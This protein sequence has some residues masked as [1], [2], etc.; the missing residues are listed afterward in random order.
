M[1]PFCVNSVYTLSAAQCQPTA[2]LP[3]PLPLPSEVWRT[4]VSYL[5]AYAA[6]Y[7]PAP[8]HSLALERLAGSRDARSV[9][10]CASAWVTAALESHVLRAWNSAC[11]VALAPSAYSAQV[12]RYC[13][14]GTAAPA[15]AQRRRRRR[16]APLGCGIDSIP[17]WARR[18]ARGGAT[19]VRRTCA[20]RAQLRTQSLVLG[21]H[22]SVA[23][24][25]MPIPSLQA[26]GRATMVLRASVRKCGAGMSALRGADGAGDARTKTKEEE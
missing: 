26:L 17:T 10:V 5:C 2:P 16:R 24:A 3:L 6:A 18:A 7:L 19:R 8:M 13:G 23:R 14:G 15:L 25:A 9:S 21:H 4:V 20:A 1:A 12:R 22:H 11:V